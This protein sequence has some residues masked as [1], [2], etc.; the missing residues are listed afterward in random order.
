MNSGKSRGV[1]MT[2]IHHPGFA[3]YPATARGVSQFE[4]DC[5]SH[6]Q[7][8]APRAVATAGKSPSLHLFSTCD[9]DSQEPALASRAEAAGPKRTHP[10]AHAAPLPGGDGG[11]SPPRRGDPQGRGGCLPGRWITQYA[12]HVFQRGKPVLS[13]VEGREAQ[14][15]FCFRRGHTE[16][17][18]LCACASLSSGRPTKKQLPRPTSLSSHIRPLCS[19]TIERTKAKPKPVPPRVRAESAR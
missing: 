13:P 11:G 16:T 10:A 9:A 4:H 8:L 17:P 7:R 2:I 12:S 3:G 6:P 1:H 5:L 18:L 14:G 19:S 15:D